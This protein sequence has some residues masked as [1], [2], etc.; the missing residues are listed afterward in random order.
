VHGEHT[1]AIGYL[2]ANERSIR[3][4]ISRGTDQALQDLA[5]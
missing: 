4:A 1:E 5:R 3:S 2:G